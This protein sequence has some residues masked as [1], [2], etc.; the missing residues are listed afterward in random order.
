MSDIP[1]SLKS[2]LLSLVEIK[3]LKI[4]KFGKKTTSAPDKIEGAED[5]S[6]SF[7][8]L[9]I[10]GNG[11][12]HGEYP[13]KVSS[14]SYLVDFIQFKTLGPL[15]S[16]EFLHQKY[17]IERLSMSQIARLVCSSTT[18]VHRYLTRY[19]LPIRTGADCHLALKGYGLAY[20]KKVQNRRLVANKKEIEVV[21]Q[22]NELRAKGFSYQKIADALNTMGIATKTGRAKW[23]A[24][25][26]QQ[27]IG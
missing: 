27:I 25:K 10:S 26:V 2:K 17:V 18:S 9:L 12:P 19:G 3:F 1:L 13:N 8:N 22:M 14:A 20:G 21:A 6:L 15:L 11:W 24:K 23:C 16:R 4:L 7:G 5:L